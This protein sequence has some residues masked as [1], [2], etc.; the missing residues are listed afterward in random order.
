MSAMGATHSLKGV[1]KL[2]WAVLAIKAKTEITFT[3]IVRRTHLSLMGSPVGQLDCLFFSG[4]ERGEG[5]IFKCNF[6]LYD[7]RYFSSYKLNPI[8]KEIT[9]LNPISEYITQINYL[10]LFIKEPLACANVHTINN[11]SENNAIED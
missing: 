11:A 9:T 10:K 5:H 8:I 3:F 2:S 7:L 1:V 6:L 4:R